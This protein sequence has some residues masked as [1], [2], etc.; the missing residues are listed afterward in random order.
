MCHPGC[1]RP[2]NTTLCSAHPLHQPAGS[3]VPLNQH[4]GAT[5]FPGWPPL[6][7]SRLSANKNPPERDARHRHRRHF[8]RN[9]FSQSQGCKKHLTVRDSEWET[10]LSTLWRTGKEG[11]DTYL[12]EDYCHLN[13]ILQTAILHS[14]ICNLQSKI[15]R[16]VDGI[17]EVPHSGEPLDKG[18][19]D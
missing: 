18:S 3:G 13:K 12:S 9:S 15:W 10:Q 2:G 1:G 8:R 14:A 17:C 11:K 4:N 6:S 16:G 19:L 7:A 5:A